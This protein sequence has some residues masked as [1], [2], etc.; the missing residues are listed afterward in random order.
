MRKSDRG[1]YARIAIDESAFIAERAKREGY[2]HAL[3]GRLGMNSIQIARVMRRY[4]G[5][6]QKALSREMEALIADVKRAIDIRPFGAIRVP[7]RL[8][9]WRRLWLW[10]TPLWLLQWWYSRAS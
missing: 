1:M 9:W 7:F 6:F 4:P 5:A 8:P 10:R 2:E 3:R